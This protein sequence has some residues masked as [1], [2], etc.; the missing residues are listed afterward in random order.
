[1]CYICGRFGWR[2]ILRRLSDRNAECWEGENCLRPQGACWVLLQKPGAP[3]THWT[4]ILSTLLP[5]SRLIDGG[6]I[7]FVSDHLR[8][9]FESFQFGLNSKT[10]FYIFRKTASFGVRL[11][12]T[13][14]RLLQFSSSP[15]VCLLGGRVPTALITWWVFPVTAHL[16]TFDITLEKG[17][18]FS[19]LS[20][21]VQGNSSGSTLR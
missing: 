4:M 10:S 15:C 7:H 11:V 18:R 17:S 5:P 14:G 6:E 3:R 2:G 21:W 20:S 13:L 9:R 16:G 12:V 19:K 1:M 8:P